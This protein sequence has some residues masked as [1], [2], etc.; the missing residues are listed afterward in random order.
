MNGNVRCV[1]VEHGV[2]DHAWCTGAC[3][4]GCVLEVCHAEEEGAA[5]AA[6]KSFHLAGCN[7]QEMLKRLGSK[8]QCCHVCHGEVKG[9][10]MWSGWE[11]DSV[12]QGGMDKIFDTCP[13]QFRMSRANVKK[14]WL[15]VPV[16]SVLDRVESDFHMEILK[17]WQLLRAQI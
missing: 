10:S 9:I 12:W 5:F 2:D 3:C 13:R 11:N 8:A 14:L 6:A 1:R 16:M 4:V 15:K 7:G 17:L